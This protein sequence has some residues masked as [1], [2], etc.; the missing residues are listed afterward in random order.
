MTLTF[1]DLSNHQGGMSLATDS[2]VKDAQAFI[3]KATEGIYFVDKT[4]D[5]FVTQAKTQNKPWGVY[6]FLDGSDVV[7]QAEFFYNNVKGYIGQGV[8]VLDYEMYGRQGASAVERFVKRFYELSGVYVWLYMNE[9]DSNSDTWSK[10]LKDNCA[11]WIAKYSTQKPNHVKGLNTIAWQYTRT[12]LDKNTF[13]G[14]ATAWKKYAQ[15][16]KQGT[17]TPITPTPAPNTIA[18]YNTS[19]TRFKALANLPIKETGDF[20]KETGLQIE[21]GKEFDVAKIINNGK[22]THAELLNG[23]GMVTLHKSYAQKIK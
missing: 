11:L 16:S 15:S 9:S 2:R 20:S 7:K 13:Y 19:G 5:G 23:L 6:H 1:Y 3:F 12:P 22:T 8:M 4:C 17:P 21:K 14:D 18:S 10:Y